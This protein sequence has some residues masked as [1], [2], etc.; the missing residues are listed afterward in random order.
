MVLPA[1]SAHAGSQVDRLQVL[2]FYQS[3]AKWRSVQP[4][5][6]D[7]RGCSPANHN[8]NRGTLQDAL[9]R[10]RD[11]VWDRGSFRTRK[12]LTMVLFPPS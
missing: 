7:S 6:R 11:E 10:R 5:S 1:P 2:R 4:N 9:T 3:S 8:L 12:Y